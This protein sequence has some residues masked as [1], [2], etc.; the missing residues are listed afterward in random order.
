MVYL[1]C[2]REWSCYWQWFYCLCSGCCRLV[3]QWLVYG[4][5][6]LSFLV[7]D[8]EQR[9]FERQVSVL[10]IIELLNFEC[11]ILWGFFRDYSFGKRRDFCCS[12]IGGFIL[13]RFFSLLV[14]IFE[15]RGVFYLFFY[16]S[17][18]IQRQGYAEQLVILV[19]LVI[20]V[21]EL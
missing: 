7:L 14:K 19:V 3:A 20:G 9:D 11:Q 21:N 2:V 10:C 16:F 6:R 17:S 4:V 1:F 13:K 5:C 12:F 15:F 8:Y 18:F